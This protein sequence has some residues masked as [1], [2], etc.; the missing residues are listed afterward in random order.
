MISLDIMLHPDYISTDQCRQ[1]DLVDDT[2]IGSPEHHRMLVHH[3]ITPLLNLPRR[4]FLC[5]EPEIV[6]QTMLPTFSM[7]RTSMSSRGSESSA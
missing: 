4:S 3:V 7:K 6:G 5:S 1:V 2:N